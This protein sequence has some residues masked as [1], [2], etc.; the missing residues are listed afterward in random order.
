PPHII[1]FHTIPAYSFFV[2]EWCSEVC[3]SDV[4]KV[5]LLKLRPVIT[6]PKDLVVFMKY[7]FLLLLQ[8]INGEV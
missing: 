7:V 1:F 2:G 3:S 8:I 5:G 4:R 6:F